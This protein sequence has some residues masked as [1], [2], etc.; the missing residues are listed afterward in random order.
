MKCDECPI[1]ELIIREPVPENSFGPCGIQL[2]DCNLTSADFPLIDAMIAG[3]WLCSTCDFW[4]KNYCRL[5]HDP[6]LCK[7]WQLKV[8]EFAYDGTKDKTDRD[9]YRGV[10]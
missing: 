1:W 8:G 5:F 3:K 9:Y 10:E 7:R 4:A 6:L 2:K